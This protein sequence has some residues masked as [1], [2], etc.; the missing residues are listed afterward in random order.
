MINQFA[1]KAS[2]AAWIDGRLAELYPET[3]IPLDYRDAYSL[4]VAVLTPSTPID[5]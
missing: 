1:T 2:R 3:P 5:M 4:L